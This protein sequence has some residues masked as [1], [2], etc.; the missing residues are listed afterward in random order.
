MKAEI[1]N[2]MGYGSMFNDSMELACH[3]H[4]AVIEEA[5]LL[6]ADAE[7]AGISQRDIVRVL[8]GYGYSSTEIADT[9]RIKRT[10]LEFDEEGFPLP[11]EEPE[12]DLS[13]ERAAWDVLATVC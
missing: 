12:F 5:A 7:S 9:L 13:P 4:Q 3:M 1:D 2:L 11:I 10:V 8:E 6:V